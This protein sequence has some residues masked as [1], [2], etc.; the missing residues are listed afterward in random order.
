GSL[1]PPVPI[2]PRSSIPALVER[3]RV[4]ADA[5]GALPVKKRAEAL[6]QVKKRFLVA[7][8]EMAAILEDEIGRPRAESYLAEI[9][10]AAAL[11]DYWCRSAPVL[12]Q[13][14]GV[15]IDPV[16][17]PRKRGVVERIPRGV[18]AVISPWN[19][20]VA[21]PLRAIVPALLAGNAVVFKPSEHAARTGAR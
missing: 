18:I 8:E 16:T 20:P 21:L 2:T 14:E 10:P 9:V 4:A 1:L 6:R 3:A 5:W 7:A 13:P 17:F 11:F 19:F 15:P 12:L